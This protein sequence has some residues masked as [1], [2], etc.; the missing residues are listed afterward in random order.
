MNRTY[1]LVVV[2]L[3]LGSALSGQDRHFSQFY[4]S[5]LTMNPAL[6][7]A[8]PGK[9]RVA[10]IY[11]DQWRPALVRPFTTFSTA[12]DF[13]FRVPRASAYRDAIGVGLVFYKDEVRNFDFTNN[14]INLSFAYHKAL[15]FRN[16]QFLSAAFQGGIAQ[17]NINF[18][19]LTFQ[20]QF[21]Q[22]DG[23]T[24]A[25]A[26]NFPGN[27]I[28]FADL[29]AG[30]NYSWVFKKNSLFQ[31]GGAIH[32]ITQPRIS[33]FPESEGGDSQLYRRY[34]VNVSFILPIADKLYI[35][36]RAHYIRQGQHQE[37][38]TGANLRMLVNDFSGV[39]LH[40]GLWGNLVTDINQA[41]ALESA[42]VFL[43]VEYAGI[44]LGMS[45]DAGISEI[46]TLGYRRGAFEL[47]LGYIGD[48][49]DEIVQCP[50]F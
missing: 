11:R 47:S 10:G 14:E 48:Y 37:W 13:R 34:Q 32:H 26:E 40:T 50:T 24:F 16:T 6:A 1:V 36:P 42:T 44:L 9:V 41:I 19:N 35:S 27:N 39:A 45:Y 20:D 29:A 3:F 46:N 33:F 17:R 8:I 28:A 30:I 38:N 22:K 43:G 15:D 31:I 25:T 21:N 23:Y 2:L 4:A 18:N 7:G 5:P 12:L 49:E